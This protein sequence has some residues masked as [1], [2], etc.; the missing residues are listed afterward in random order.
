[1]EIQAE[2]GLRIPN[3]FEAA[4]DGSFKALYVHGED[5]AQSDP[6]TNHVSAALGAMECVIVQ[7]LF[8]NE[9]ARFAHVFFPGS[10]FL[11]KDGTFTNAERRI[12]R[13]RQVVPPLPPLG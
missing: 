2:P 1:V 5:I 7:D 10:S 12:S 13:V 4:L 11:E 9:T 6:N 8:L 3:M